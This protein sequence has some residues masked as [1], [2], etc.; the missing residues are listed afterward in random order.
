MRFGEGDDVDCLFEEF[1]ASVVETIFE[2]WPSWILRAI[3]S[4]EVKTLRSDP[5][6]PL[7]ALSVSFGAMSTRNALM[8]LTTWMSATLRLR[9]R[10][11][12]LVW[13]GNCRWRGT[14]TV[15]VIQNWES[16]SASE[17]RKAVTSLSE[18]CWERFLRL[19]RGSSLAS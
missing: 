6:L 2:S 12:L 15:L 9:S 18:S 17:Q 10:R 7:S 14:R 11:L 8:R 19:Y 4:S 5:F 1:G 16:C 3:K 13:Q